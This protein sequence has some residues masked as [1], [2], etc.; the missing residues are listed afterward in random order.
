[1]PPTVLG[2]AAVHPWEEWRVYPLGMAYWFNPVTGE[3]APHETFVSRHN[4]AG[5]ICCLVDRVSYFLRA[6]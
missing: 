3:R 1:M 4:I 6:V 2:E 5:L